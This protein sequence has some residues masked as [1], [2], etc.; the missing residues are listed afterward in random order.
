MRLERHHLRIGETIAT[1][2]VDSKYLHIAYDAVRVAREQIMRHIERDPYFMSSHRPVDVP[3]NAPELVERMAHASERVGVGPMAAVAGA[4]AQYAT[5]RLVAAGADHVVFDNGGDIAM[6]LEHPIIAGLYTGSKKLNCLGFKVNEI[7]T[8]VGLCTSSA[9][10]GHSLSY[11]STDASVVYSND[12]ALADASAT[13]LG[14]L[15][16]TDNP[17]VVERSLY[18]VLS[19]GIRGAMVVIGDAVGTC[20]ELPEIVRARVDYDLISKGLEG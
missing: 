17:S 4:I 6:Y 9:T 10:V 12:V 3:R 8:L 20:G 14:N 7:H 2:L 15:V 11:G 16:T 19:H 1:V 5:E 18:A 13:A